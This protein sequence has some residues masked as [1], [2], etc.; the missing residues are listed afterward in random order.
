MRQT[1]PSYEREAREFVEQVGPGESS[2]TRYDRQITRTAQKWLQDRAAEP[3][4][5]PWVLFLSFVCP[6]Y[7]LYAPQEFFEMYD[8]AQVDLP[9]AA[10]PDD[11]PQHAV[12]RE[13]YDF[14]NYDQFFDEARVRLAR[15]CYYALCSFLDHNIG[16]V[17]NTLET[18]GLTDDTRVIYTSDHGELLGNHGQWTKMLMYEDSVAVPFIMSGPEVPQGKVIDTPISLVDSYQTIVEGV[19]KTLTEAEQAL[20]GQSLFDIIATEPEGRVTF[21]EYHD[22][23]VTTGFYMLRL[24]P[25]KYVYYV[26][27][28]PQLFNLVED[29]QELLDL[30]E[31]PDYVSIRGKCEAALRTIV[32]LEAANAQAHADQS[33]KLAEMGGREAALALP[34]S[35]FGFTPLKHLDLDS[36]N[37]P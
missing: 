22:G 6:H 19:G 7:P 5:K 25:W 12:L 20:P 27:H 18:S 32:D 34:D 29:P 21:S 35:D 10:D 3:E 4:E 9:F 16:Q 37:L 24:G 13:F 33:R 30:G 26:G 14:Y 17:L 2:Y 1:L 23:G 28:P 31:H 8:P 11:W 36:D 15:A